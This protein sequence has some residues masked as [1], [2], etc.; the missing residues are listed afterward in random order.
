MTKYRRQGSY[1][2]DIGSLVWQASRGFTLAM[3]HFSPLLPY[4]HF[5]FASTAYTLSYILIF[6]SLQILVPQLFFHAPCLAATEVRHH[7]YLQ[8]TEVPA[9]TVIWV[10][11]PSFLPI[12]LISPFY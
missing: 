1:P 4:F 7:L 8:D 3:H 12:E 6:C 2:A 5:I 11:P 9:C 10:T